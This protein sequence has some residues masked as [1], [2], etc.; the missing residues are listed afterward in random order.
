MR[1]IC[2]DRTVFI[3]AHRLNAVRN[4]HR[5]LVID[6]GQIVESG[7]HHDLIEASGYYAKLYSH[8]AGMVIGGQGSGLKDQGQRHDA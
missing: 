2:K 8:Q 4:A 7:S 5:I 3:I 6:K 1:Y